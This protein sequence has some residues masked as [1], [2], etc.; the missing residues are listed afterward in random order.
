ML[1]V[2]TYKLLE[3]SDRKDVHG[4]QKM[5]VDLQ[6]HSAEQRPT[7]RR[8]QPGLGGAALGAVR[9]QIQPRAGQAALLDRTSPQAHPQAHGGQS[10]YD[11][12][13]IRLTLHL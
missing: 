1:V 4:E 11:L 3:Q 5:L 2:Q 8:Q 13:C 12:Y 10:R 7:G 6:A 9:L